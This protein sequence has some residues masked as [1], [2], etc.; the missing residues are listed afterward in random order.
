MFVSKILIVLSLL[1]KTHVGVHNINESSQNLVTLLSVAKAA[2][3]IT[4]TGSPHLFA[5]KAAFSGLY[6]PL[7]WALSHLSLLLLII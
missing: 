3:S 6:S 5:L 4:I 7:M 2:T 1:F